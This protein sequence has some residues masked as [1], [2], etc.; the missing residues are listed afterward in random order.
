MAWPRA[1]QAPTPHENTRAD[2]IAVAVGLAVWLK[3]MAAKKKAA[4][5]AA[6]A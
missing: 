5:A 3:S 4:K 6:T 1:S 2:L